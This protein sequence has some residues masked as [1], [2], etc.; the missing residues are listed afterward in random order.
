MKHKPVWMIDQNRRPARCEISVLTR[1]AVV[2]F[3]V[4]VALEI[5]T[6]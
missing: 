5:I 4:L 2:A 1:C 6:R 3:F